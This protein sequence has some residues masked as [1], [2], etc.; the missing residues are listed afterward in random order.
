MAPRT[1]TMQWLFF[2]GPDGIVRSTR[3]RDQAETQAALV[4][5]GLAEQFV[6]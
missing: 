4:C 1:T 6:R 2:I 3:S 5:Q